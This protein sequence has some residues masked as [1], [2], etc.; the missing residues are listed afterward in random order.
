MS[1]PRLAVDIQRVSNEDILR[2]RD[3]LQN[4]RHQDFKSRRGRKRGKSNG[5]V[6]LNNIITDS[7]RSRLTSLKTKTNFQDMSDNDD[8]EDKETK[9]IRTKNVNILRKKKNV[10]S[11]NLK[12]SGKPPKIYYDKSDKISC[13]KCGR[14][15]HR[16]GIK[17]HL[18]CHSKERFIKV[19]SNE[20]KMQC[21]V[22]QSY[23]STYHG[24]KK[25]FVA[26]HIENNPFYCRFPGCNFKGGEYYHFE[27]HVGRHIEENKLKCSNCE[28]AFTKFDSLVRHRKI[29]IETG[30]IMRKRCGLSVVQ[31]K[32]VT[33]KD[34]SK[35]DGDSEIVEVK[36]E[37]IIETESIHL[38]DKIVET[39]EGPIHIKGENLD[40]FSEV[41]NN[42]NDS[43]VM[44]V[45]Q[46]KVD[47]IDS[48]KN[49]DDTESESEK[50]WDESKIREMIAKKIASWNDKLRDVGYINS[51][52]KAD[53]LF[54]K[55]EMENAEFTKL[56]IRG[57]GRKN[58][59]AIN[60][61]K[62]YRC[63]ICSRAFRRYYGLQNHKKQN[64]C[65]FMSKSN[66]KSSTNENTNGSI[67]KGDDNTEKVDVN[68]SATQKSDQSLDFMCAGCGFQSTSALE[69]ELHMK[70]SP[71]HNKT[72]FLSHTHPCPKKCGGWF[73]S[74]QQLNEH[75][76]EAHDK[77]PD[78][79]CDKCDKVFTNAKY[80]RRHV[81][82]THTNPRIHPC[83][84][85]GRK[86]S[87]KESSESHAEKC[88]I[89]ICR[90]KCL[91]CGEYFSNTHSLRRHVMCIHANKSLSKDKNDSNLL[92]NGS[93]LEDHTHKAKV[94]KEVDP[95]SVEVGNDGLNSMILGI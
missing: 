27:R 29:C 11:S 51:I 46:A 7:K 94:E 54:Q 24:L 40:V 71:A 18:E 36:T 19:I 49:E 82:N 34:F 41:S 64:I 87:S 88:S 37:R 66:V 33:A 5:G 31:Y 63:N 35:K 6:D 16:S 84:R 83:F 67:S 1:F 86:F 89:K 42:K 43:F 2:V 50:K 20:S 14:S 13:L 95:D 44:H 21:V 58:Y 56:I 28:R 10:K 3:N 52:I 47:S 39:E 8:D 81:Y 12:L 30:G 53:P 72:Q 55:L 75:I 57:G 15:V 38:F 73:S 70:N 45:K 78:M 4:K 61:L 62:S 17:R 92:E 79:K 91:Q 68:A 93:R 76:E 22:C 85:C 60:K 90:P 65:N 74:I 48:D 69:L 80:L 23:F 9:N 59:F 25:H 32:R 26:L 77:V